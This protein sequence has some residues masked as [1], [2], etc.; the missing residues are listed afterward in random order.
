LN[1]TKNV[2]SVLVT[3]ILIFLVSIP[4]AIIVARVLGPEG[5][6][7]YA[8][9]MLVP[10]MLYILANLGL[11]GANI[12]FIG[13]KKFSPTDIA[14]NSLVFGFMVSILLGIL[15]A[16]AYRFFLYP[17]FADVEPLLIYLII[18]SLPFSL[19]AVYFKG[20]LL[21]K[22]K[23]KEY[24][25]LNTLDPLLLL[26]GVALLLILFN[27]GIFSLVLLSILVTV[28]TLCVSSFL[29]HKMTKIR[30]LLRVN[31]L[32]ESLKYGVRV[33]LANILTFLCYRL[34]MLLVAYYLGAT[35]V[36]FYALAVGMAEMVWILSRAVQTILFPLV[37]SSEQSESRVLSAVVARHTLFL[38]LLG[39]IGL[40][41]VGRWVIEIFY[42][43]QFLPSFVPLLILLPGILSFAFVGAPVSYLSGIGRP[44]FAT[45]A[46]LIALVVNIGLNMILIPKWGIAGAAFATTIA[47]SL[48]TLIVLLS[49]L[50][51]SQ[52]MLAS[53]MI[54]NSDDFRIYFNL[55]AK[56]LRRRKK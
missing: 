28:I 55:V 41:V 24:N 45:W 14:S 9:V 53:C 5:K 7:I 25:L 30:F 43:S 22:F 54:M 56:V 33:Y 4:N 40:A 2:T 19:I 37:S 23:I 36:G 1:F 27:K 21:A 34:D 49:Y 11:S 47:Y 18:L 15:F 31:M 12:Y 26:I 51:M 3:N 42:G 8:L 39:C 48:A 6:G 44:I 32:K 16:L 50:K 46:S 17:F 10:G 38:S 35:Q 52:N 13:S 20:I 29:V